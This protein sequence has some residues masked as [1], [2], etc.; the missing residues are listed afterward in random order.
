MM[1]YHGSP[2]GG[3]TELKPSATKHFGK[4]KQV[5]MT[6]LR[7]MALLYLIDNFEYT[8]GYDKTGQIYYEE[9]YPNSLQKL[10]Q[11]KSGYLYVCETGEYDGTEI[12][13]EYVS[14]NPVKILS[15]EYIPD[16]FEAIQTAANNGEI[17]LRSY[18]ELSENT[19]K[20]VKDW[21][22]RDIKKKELWKTPSPYA[23]YLKENYPEIWNKTILEI[24][25][26]E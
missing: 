21:Y 15:W 3:L 17:I 10:Y 23:A 12:P 19:H 1:F 8:Y 5:C 13:N 4:P 20:M 24:D 16:A 2:V 26:K 9:Y 25:T 22:A 6:S 7:V 11:G 18:E 14:P